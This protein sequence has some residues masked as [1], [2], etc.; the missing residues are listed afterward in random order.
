MRT[1]RPLALYG[2]RLLVAT[3]PTPS[4][5]FLLAPAHRCFH[6]HIQLQAV[7][8]YKQPSLLESYRYKHDL[9]RDAAS[10]DLG[11]RGN[12]TAT[13]LQT[14]EGQTNTAALTAVM[15]R[16]GRAA[17]PAAPHEHVATRHTLNYA[18]GN[19]GGKQ[20]SWMI[21]GQPPSVSATIPT[22]QTDAPRK[23]GR[24][25]K[26]PQEYAQAQ[27]QAPPPA[28]AQHALPPQTTR[29][30]P[31]SNSTSPQLANVLS[32][33]S[34]AQPL[35]SPTAILPSPSPSEE[36]N[37]DHRPQVAA[38]AAPGHGVLGAPFP[39]GPSLDIRNSSPED[40]FLQGA[41][42]AASKRPAPGTDRELTIKRIR[43]TDSACERPIPPPLR[44][45]S[46]SVLQQ[47]TG[48]P[49]STASI[50]TASPTIIQPLSST[51]RQP[52][53][54][55]SP[56]QATFQPVHVQQRP[57]SQ[58]LVHHHHGT[59]PP[60]HNPL[61][62][63]QPS[64][65]P[66]QTISA[67][68]FPTQMLL[69]LKA[70]CVQ[71]IQRFLDTNN[72]NEASSDHKRSSA[73]KVAA[74]Q[75]DWEFMMTHLFY[76]LLTLN[77]AALPQI[78][79]ESPHVTASTT[80]LSEILDVNHYLTPST[81]HF[82]Q[83]YPLPFPLTEWAHRNPQQF[84]I[85][86]ENFKNLMSRS[87]RYL[88]LKQQCF[89]RDFPPSMHEMVYDLGI[90]SKMLQQIIFLAAARR[91]WFSWGHDGIILFDQY[92][93]EVL[94]RFK[95][96]QKTF[97]DRL[98]QGADAK[99][100]RK[101]ELR[102]WRDT[103]TKLRSE[104]ATAVQVV[105]RSTH[106]TQQTPISTNQQGSLRSPRPMRTSS[107][108]GHQP[109]VVQQLVYPDPRMPHH[110]SQATFQQG[111]G[112]PRGRPRLAT[113]QPR[114]QH[115]SLTQYQPQT[116]SRPRSFLPPPRHYEPQQRQ[117]NPARY[118][119]HQAHLRSATLRSRTGERLYHF[120]QSF[121]KEPRHLVDARDK[122]ERWSFNITSEQ[123]AEIPQETPA[124]LG[125][126][127]VRIVDDKSFML[128]LR[129][130]KW[131]ITQSPNEHSWASSDTSWIPYSYFTLNGKSLEQRK[132]LHYGKDL[133]IDLTSTIK[134]GENNLEIALLKTP[135]NEHF[136]NYLVAIE[137]LRVKTH[138][139]LLEDIQRNNHVSAA[140]TRQRIMEKLTSNNGDEDDEIAVVNSTLNITLFDPFVG[141][142]MCDIPARSRACDH[143]NCFDLVTFLETR[144]R[145]GD[146]SV[147]DHWR[148]PICNGDARPQHLI[149]D[150]FMEE[151][152]SE[153]EKQGL[154]NTRAIVMSEDGSWKP[155]VEVLEGV[156]DQ[157]NEED[158]GVVAG[159][160]TATPGQHPSK[161]PVLQGREVIDLGDSEDD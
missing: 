74:L 106:S 137:V 115:Q 69:D 24:P 41:R 153:L 10:T 130:V 49:V 67:S 98:N 20:K 78:I 64:P 157:E 80:F 19:L 95:L 101:I 12:V 113:H 114:P 156:A 155:K 45:S 46:D 140:T 16:G 40:L 51:L 61:A 9:V 2:K 83:R 33:R 57:M 96:V 88:E 79:R 147:P 144:N 7:Q 133:P 131:S 100:E 4:R 32:H 13:S 141:S 139:A 39:V 123:I 30:H 47:D 31:P 50:Q 117:P 8:C 5:A 120:V 52:T 127:A 29:E 37:V 71:E 35:P 36:A 62:P 112:R 85:D 124:T 18:L 143:F 65:I 28:P 59:T 54:S 99:R 132:K 87:G 105:R 44:V 56:S 111:R 116:V 60:V 159:N 3:S 58:P 152:R 107:G 160:G 11:R 81:Q 82:F 17:A 43:T 70:Y 84:Q 128:R 55:Q 103:F 135:E 73:L 119:L 6:T 122:V 34:N 149:V 68:S 22:P 14:S 25:R 93:S 138:S 63:P 118:G 66:G 104:F 154:M 38:T 136:D 134:E 75:F 26:Y 146:S 148:C 97:Y 23:R 151:V 1:K 72:M 21:S 42:L 110:Q 92:D 91:L 94:Q 15:T 145:H 150:G 125:G 86:V 108:S 77:Q 102:W 76:C 161:T 27:A 129:C 53:N 89:E 126:P 158:D 48:R 121:L 109:P 142:K 90:V